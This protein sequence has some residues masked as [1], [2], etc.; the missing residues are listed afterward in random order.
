MLNE[1][2]SHFWETETIKDCNKSLSFIANKYSANESIIYTLSGRTALDLIIR[3]IKKTRDIKNVYMPS[4]CCHSMLVPFVKHNIK[5]YFYDI[6][7]DEKNNL[8]FKIDLNKKYDVVFLIQYFG[9]KNISIEE[10]IKQFQNN[11]SL[12]IEDKTHSLL[13]D[14]GSAADYTFASCRKWTG[15]ASGGIAAKNAGSFAINK[16]INTNENFVKLRSDAEQL[17]KDYIEKGFG[18][19]SEFLS[20]YNKAEELLDL[21]YSKYLMDSNSISL[22]QQLDTQVIKRKRVI[23][24]KIL[25][26][27]LSNLKCVNPIFKKVQEGDAPLFFPVIA[28][29]GKRDKLKHFLVEN[30]IYCPS[31]W[32][33]SPYHIIS[34]DSK[35]IYEKEL[36]LVC[37]QRY[38][39]EEMQKE[40]EVIKNFE[41]DDLYAGNNIR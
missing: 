24:A 39:E 5:I 6:V 38:G 7:L 1:I 35:Q 22:F 29:N 21:D 9:Y 31:H 11:G 13:I 8:K 10:I 26:K 14:Q 30:E 27:G 12:I 34:A 40:I 17:K 19:K 15:L 25:L 28:E 37:D 18:D 33:L 16:L 32:I 41:R 20:L 36:S 23:N 4:Y 3:D 2:G